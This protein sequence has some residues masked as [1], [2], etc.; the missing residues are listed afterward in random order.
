MYIYITY[1]KQLHFTG[2]KSRI[3]THEHLVITKILTF[4]NKS[5]IFFSEKREIVTA[6]IFLK[7]LQHPPKN[8]I[9]LTIYIANKWCTVQESKTNQLFIVNFTYL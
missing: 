8:I 9:T 1:L 2:P 4:N 7:P 3:Q 6:W 5:K